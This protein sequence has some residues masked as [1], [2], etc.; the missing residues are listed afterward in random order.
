MVR[1]Q[2]TRLISGNPDRGRMPG[3]ATEAVPEVGGHQV[4][5]A[6]P[7][8][9]LQGA[10]VE[11][12]DVLGEGL[13]AA[14]VQQGEAV[15]LAAQDDALEA[16]ARGGPGLGAQVVE[17]LPDRGSAG[18]VVTARGPGEGRAGPGAGAGARS[19]R[20]PAAG[21]PTWCSS[22]P[23]STRRKRS[24]GQPPGPLSAASPAT[25]L[26]QPLEGVPREGGCPRAS[27]PMRMPTRCRPAAPASKRQSRI[28]VSRV[29][30][31][32]STATPLLGESVV[33]EPAVLHEVAVAA[34]V[35][36]GG[37]AEEQADAVVALEEG[38]RQPV[39]GVAGGRC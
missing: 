29:S 10:P 3:E 21:G 31:R 22:W 34:A 35:P 23:K 39:V 6:A 7:V 2:W 13:A 27:P 19:G 24:T 32:T 1:A 36:G 26:D 11:P 9:L 16:G 37:L 5:G 18:T 15:H 28:S 4:E 33:D 17:A 20:S 25:S 14:R 12:G 30:P 38:V 8:D